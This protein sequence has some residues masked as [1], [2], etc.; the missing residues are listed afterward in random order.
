[1]Q[2]NEQKAAVLTALRAGRTQTEA[3]HIAGV[4]AATV[5]TWVHNGRKKPDGPWA[6]FAEAATRSLP[7]VP[8][9]MP[10]RD[11]LLYLLGQRAR[12]GNMR[13]IE[14]LLRETGSPLPP[15]QTDKA[16]PFSEVD[17]LAARRRTH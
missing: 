12:E 5:R 3:A 1:L 6:P 17:E 7:V 11:E 8:G 10:A 2:S 15:E 9:T 13:A 4:P 14:L 16:D